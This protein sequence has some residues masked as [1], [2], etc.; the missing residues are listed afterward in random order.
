MNESMPS[1][2]VLGDLPALE[3]HL[4]DEI[5]ACK[6]GDPLAPVY[7]LIGSN[8]LRP[9]LRRRL[10]AI[11]GGQINLHLLTPNDLARSLG[12]AAQASS[13][14]RPLPVFGDRYLARRVSET[15]A[16][17]YFDPVSR[18]PG[19]AETLRRLFRE[20][21]Q[22]GV[23]IDAWRV[24]LDG[25]AID[26]T[27]KFRDIARLYD[28][29]AT[30]L[31]RFY[32]AE[33]CYQT[34]DAAQFPSN[35]LLIYGMWSLT[36]SQRR[37]LEQ[38][39]AHAELTV[40]LPWTGTDADDAH[41][42]MR[43]WLDGLG[44]A[45]QRLAP[46]PAEDSTLD[47]LRRRLFHPVSD[48]VLLDGTVRLLSAPD[49]PRE[50]REAART[51][52]HWAKQHG[53][54]FH[55]MAVAYRHS[56]RYRTLIDQVFRQA[57]IATYLHEK[58]R[59]IEVPAGQRVLAL[60][61]LIGSDLTR[62][63]VMDFLSETVLP[64]STLQRYSE[65]DTEIQIPVWDQF[66]REA[67]I[68]EG[69]NQWESRLTALRESKSEFAE[70]DDERYGER[71][72]R[73]LAEIDR[74]QRFIADFAN[75]LEKASDLATWPGHV[76]ALRALASS[77]IAGVEDVTERLDLL[78]PLAEL[79]HN[80]AVTFE[81]FRETVRAWLERQTSSN[82]NGSTGD[83][84][85]TSPPDGQFGRLGVNVL[86]V[87][88][89]RHLRFRAV[90]I[91][92]VAERQ[93]PAPPRQDPLLLDRERKDLNDRHRWGLP[94]RALGP[95]DEA[96]QF[97]LAVQAATERIQISFPRGDAGS[98]R[99]H[100]PSHFFRSAAAA[101]VG[102]SVEAGHIDRVDDALYT[103]VPAGTLGL[104]AMR[105]SDAS[106]E[107]EPVVALD[108][109]EYDRHLLERN[110][111]R[112][113][114]V[115]GEDRRSVSRAREAD[116]ARRG[117]GLTAYDGV[118]EI[119]HGGE[120]DS[121]TATRRAISPSRLETYAT[122]PYRYF[123]NYVLALKP[124]EEPELLERISPL[125][126]GSLVHRVLEDF[127][128]E[129]GHDDPPSDHRRDAHLSL[130]HR[131]ARRHCDRLEQQGLVG[132]RVLWE[133]DRIAILEDLEEWYEHE[134]ADYR[135]NGLLP[136]TFELRF[137]PA[138]RGETTGQYSRDEPFT[139]RIDRGEIR[140]Q[141]RADRA[142]VSPDRSRFRVIDYK[143]GRVGDWYRMNALS[144]GRALQLPIYLLATSELL[145]IP[146]QQ[147][148]A[149]YFF[150][151]RRGEYKRIGLDGEWLAGNIDG[152]TDLLAGMVE[153]MEAG[154]FLQTPR[155]KRSVNNCQY[156]DY[157]TVCPGNVARVAERK[158]A[159]PRAARFLQLIE[160]EL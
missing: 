147:S 115:C 150:V 101:L 8:L 95:D 65:P 104:Y 1:R 44:A 155:I 82:L 79:D 2:I 131:I 4:A 90:V 122:C 103:R 132:Y 21:G 118:F 157:E 43:D 26:R 93:F 15:T 48:A 144:G 45:V 100:L 129:C 89:L 159:S 56:D 94:L 30:R 50:V 135:E 76:D 51:C 27:G 98:S 141:G 72:R 99:S 39:N 29:H 16:T 123:L 125:E 154:L 54:P 153:S 73:E 53:I 91:L 78:K 60:L 114:D 22:A 148:R 23:D 149:E 36:T 85:E 35:C 24:A 46:S 151:S 55:E 33:D 63:S 138:W 25:G 62:A 106:E 52:L 77:Y 47:H 116:D 75:D 120:I 19:F 69:K 38:I 108:L 127:L 107:P 20:F 158:R 67:N 112:G 61:N 57:G 109:H 41:L 83:G 14:R 145:D 133:Y 68:V 105:A 97:A 11:A 59:L 121:W 6:N 119:D 134:V 117:G 81:H 64:E 13:G 37:L 3:A 143:S 124:I 126:R 7:L 31:V 160:A 9:Y 152:F 128:K 70:I 140:F 88:S 28:E 58:R 34:A 111:D 5:H 142:D 10:A 139:L 87:N 74:F 156:C 92:G 42:E 40:F 49:Q 110:P 32:T 17:R 86:D 113:L 136:L 66:S 12:E 71:L 80:S 84:A 18:S 130:L 102:E 137:G 146:W 96:L